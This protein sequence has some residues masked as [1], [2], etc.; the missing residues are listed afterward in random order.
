M[1]ARSLFLAGHHGGQ[2]F[3]LSMPKQFSEMGFLIRSAQNHRDDCHE[4]NDIAEA[5][6][7]GYG[8]KVLLKAL[9]SAIINPEIMLQV[10]ILAVKI[11]QA[12]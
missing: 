10:Q 5:M 4:D 8:D 12:K 7:H 9:P 6:H 1:L 3:Q 2:I 11:E